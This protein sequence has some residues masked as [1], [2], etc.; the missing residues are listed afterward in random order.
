MAVIR[1]LR[2]SALFAALGT[3]AL[4]RA[5]AA[6]PLRDAPIVW[7]MDDRR[8]APKPA[9]RDPNLLRDGIEESFFNPLG[10]L[11][12]PSRLIR[13]VGTIFGGD[14]VQAASNLNAL[15]EVPNSAWF[16]NRIGLQPVTP[17]DAARGPTVDE[18]P[19]RSAPWTVVRAKTQGVTPGFSIRDARGHT[20]LLKFDPPCCPGMSSAAGVITG[21]ILHTV[22]YNVPEDFVVT[23]RREDLVL[24]EK[25]T[26]TDAHG[27]KRPMTT[28]DLD[29]ILESVVRDPD[30]GW[31][32]IASKFLS[33]TPVGPFSWRGKRKD[34]PLDP[35][36]H[37]NRRELRGL[38][39]IAAWLG[40]FDMKQGNTL[41][42]YVEDGG[43]HYVRHYLIDFASTLGAGA[44][45][46]Y[47]LANYEY[48]FDPP[49]VGG[50]ALALGFHQSPWER[51]ERPKGL[52]EIGYLESREFEPSKWKPLDPNG[53]FANLTDRDGYWAAKVVSAFTDEQ[54]EAAVDEGRYRDPEAA[55]YVVRMLKE[56]R[57]KVARHWF[58]RVA[59]LDFFTIEGEEV[60]FHD[61][62][63]ERAI[64]P[65]TTPSYRTRI[66]AVQ[67]D[68]GGAEWS[69]WSEVSKPAMDLSVA[70]AV[71]PIRS[72]PIEKKPFL[73]IQAQVNRGSGWSPSV[74]VYISRASGRIVALSR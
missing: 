72:A 62:G 22:G 56:R 67:A 8:D 24:G 20:Y 37:E 58:D 49:A 40:H 50:R 63:Q 1:F 43:R 46:P 38:R 42:M 47:P 4:G 13:K 52:E 35:V 28:D 23:F 6:E 3:C 32:A 64:Y 14:H 34:D 21:R 68:R 59:P 29:R 65:G 2:A 55:H 33:G 16:T 44:A 26:F 7:E 15:D 71:E 39:V 30:G 41:D 17:A 31:R 12:N 19:D 45:G 73:A 69:G 70:V 53:A 60:R 57:D 51:I 74:T 27:V 48:A 54:L 10:R 61:L 25:V 11:L 36:R 66:A 18:G 9:E 5:V